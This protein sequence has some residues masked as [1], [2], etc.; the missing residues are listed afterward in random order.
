M[1]HWNTKAWQ[2]IAIYK[3]IEYCK[4]RP[5]YNDRD[6]YILWEAYLDYVKLWE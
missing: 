6:K 1:K 5:D 3:F 4:E 2:N